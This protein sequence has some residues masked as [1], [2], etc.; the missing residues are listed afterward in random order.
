MP[1]QSKMVDGVERNSRR[2][3][4]LIEDLLTIS[5]IEA[6]AFHIT[7]EQIDIR[8]LVATVGESLQA[9]AEAASITLRVTTARESSALMAEADA[10]ALERA[11][12]NIVANAIKFSP[13]GGAVDLSATRLGEAIEI[14]VV[15]R[16]IGI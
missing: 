13:P 14:V 3:L 7:R 4:G 2:L 16:G 6:G 9:T 10:H 1:E 12:I 11:L 15:D 5:Q 8:P